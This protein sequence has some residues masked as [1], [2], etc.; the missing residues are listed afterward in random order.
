MV[1]LIAPDDF[2]PDDA[3]DAQWFHD[4]DGAPAL[5][6]PHCEEEAREFVLMN[7]GD[8]LLTEARIWFDRYLRVNAEME[9]H[10]EVPY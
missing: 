9:C 6:P 2:D 4:H 7:G 10:D 3:R 5:E 1:H 8:M